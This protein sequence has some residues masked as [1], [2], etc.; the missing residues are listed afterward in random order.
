MHL[1]LIVLPDHALTGPYQVAVWLSRLDLEHDRF[2]SLIDQ[3]DVG[4]RT[5][6][7]PWP[8]ANVGDWVECNKLPPVLLLLGWRS[9]RC[10][11][12]LHCHTTL[13]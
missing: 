2:V 5:I 11:C 8:E 4:G 9:K 13:Y 7:L 6:A 12:R 1:N 3:L 10:L